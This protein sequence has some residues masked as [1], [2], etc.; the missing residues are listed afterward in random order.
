M[1]NLLILWDWDNT[2]NDTSA[3][4]F[5]SL[6]ETAEH[7][8]AP[9]PTKHDLREVLSQ[10]KGPYWERTY[11]SDTQE[12]MDYYL[13]RFSANHLEARLFPEAKEILTFVHQSKT[14]QLII[15]NKRKDLLKD[16][17]EQA[18]IKHL[19]DGYI[20][21]D[22]AFSKI[23]PMPN[24]GAEVIAQIPH[25]QLLMI[26]DGT[27]DMEYAQAIGAIGV[28]IRA[29]EEVESY[30]TPQFCFN[31]LNEVAGWLKTYIVNE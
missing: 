30:I 4:I 13:N 5:K 10:H 18:N 20:G 8:G 15:S 23:K 25:E 12:A 14:A 22:N 3:M 28:Y 27:C 1:R 2:L 7:Y 6:Q 11:A 24:Y 29:K 19:I 9:M 21:A 26:G 16:E 17:I 31:N